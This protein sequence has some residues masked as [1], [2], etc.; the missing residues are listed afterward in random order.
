MYSDL[1]FF[2]ISFIAII[3]MLYGLKNIAHLFSPGV[4][5]LNKYRSYGEISIVK[6]I[7]DRGR[8]G[9]KILGVVIFAILSFCL[10]LL[11]RN[12]IF[13]IFSGICLWIYIIDFLNG[14]EKKRK[15]LLNN[16]IVE[17]LNNMAV[18]LKAGNT[19]RNIFKSSAGYFKNPL[20]KYLVDTANELEL[21]FTLDEALDRFS[22]RCRSR[23]VDLLV[24]SL[25]IN[26]K[27][28]GDLI[29]IIDSVSNS[30]RHNLKLKSKVKTMSL[31]SRYSGNI[32]SIFPIIVLILMCIFF[33]DTVMDFFSTGAGIISLA[34]GGALEIIGIV[35]IKKII[36]IEN[37][38][39]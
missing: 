11:S 18:M 25:K 4:R 26:N 35:I 28:G 9:K 7:L 14:F 38:N 2:A 20:N 19:I 10:F 27:I 37:F 3:L 15:D 21:N 24:S 6:Y 23:E 31:Q 29:S 22:G 32:I 36:G 1:L 30:I 5:I 8:S 12:F 39:G 13:S 16:Q 17:F 33:S 34:A